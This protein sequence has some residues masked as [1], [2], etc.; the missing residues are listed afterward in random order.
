[1]KSRSV[2]I[3]TTMVAF[4]AMSRSSAQA[5][6]L[7]ID[8]F[9]EYTNNQ[10]LASSSTSSPWLRFGS[11]E[12][13]LYAKAGAA[14]DGALGAQIPVDPGG[15]NGFAITAFNFGTATNLSAYSTASVLS[16]S[17]AASA[18][19]DGLKL[20]LS[21]GG[22]TYVSTVAQ[23]E[24]N[25]AQTYTFPL[26][27]SAFTRTSSGSGGT[28]SFAITLGAATQIGFEINNYSGG[29]A[30]GETIAF[31][32]FAVQSTPEPA[33][34]SLILIG[35]AGLAMKRRRTGVSSSVSL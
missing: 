22:T 17:L 18:S 7:T 28:D 23:Q 25:S 3:L 6:S 2:F 8:N 30:V 33:S 29:T 4:I 11:V 5:Q 14:M 24:G 10:T 19:V 26:S 34:A 12:D 16:K 32:D 27:S 1:M 31:D 15:A 9:E 21:D 35:L 13:N 20:F